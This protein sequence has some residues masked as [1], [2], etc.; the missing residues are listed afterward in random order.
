M[1]H[2][3]GTP[4]LDFDGQFTA[5]IVP[6]EN[7]MKKDGATGFTVAVLINPDT[8]STS[9]T[10]QNRYIAMKVDDANNMWAL[11]LDP[12][13]K[14]F[15]SGLGGFSNNFTSSNFDKNIN[16][17]GGSG[18][19]LHFTV[20]HNGTSYSVKTD[21]GV[22]GLLQRNTW[23][24]I[25][26]A[27]GIPSGSQQGSVVY[28]NSK[29]VSTSADPVTET[30]FP[31]AK[32]SLSVGCNSGDDGFFS[33]LM[34]DFRFYYNKVLNQF[35]AYNLNQNM[36]TIAPIK[37]GQVAI[38]GASITNPTGLINR[39]YL[40]FTRASIQEVTVPN[41]AVFNNL[42]AFTISC[43]IYRTSKGAG[44]TF[45]TYINKGWASAGSFTLFET[46]SGTIGFGV[47]NVSTQAQD[48]TNGVTDNV[49]HHV[50]GVYDGASIRLYVDGIQSSPVAVTG[51]MTLTSTFEIGAVSGGGTSNAF[52][53]RIA[54]VR[55]YNVALTATEIIRLFADTDIIN[56]GLVARFVFDEGSGT[57]AN[58]HYNNLVGTLV[59]G[60][61]WGT[62][63]V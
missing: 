28:M 36:I 24:W 6:E 13:T 3:G 52:N 30:S 38:T 46:S 20:F 35:D 22:K 59:N 5:I 25:V 15:Q 32:T 53:G 17:V 18:N 12:T 55:I 56:R 62:T 60:P 42:T 9:V 43:W 23:Y 40:N 61:T 4:C 50:V 8:F 31:F 45:P 29:I 57:V 27:F 47:N 33:G 41:N 37:F 48:T 49:W 19:A 14:T 16:V 58:D 2:L 7:N 11:W 54:G 39:P 63:Q 44:G 26:A 51:T 10:G 1:I 34:S 21:A